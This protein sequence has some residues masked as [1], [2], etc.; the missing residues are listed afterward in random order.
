MAP[1]PTL[2]TDPFDPGAAGAEFR[3]MV[4]S[5]HAQGLEVI[6]EAS[7]AWSSRGGLEGM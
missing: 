2:S 6:M 3:A 7:S 1:D 5:L 4:D